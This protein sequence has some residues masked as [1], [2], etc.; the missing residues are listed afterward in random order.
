MRLVGLRVDVSIKASF[1]VR[2]RVR[3]TFKVGGEGESL[4]IVFGLSKVKVLRFSVRVTF[5]AVNIKVYSYGLGSRL[6]LAL[7]RARAVSALGLLMRSMSERVIVIP[8]HVAG[9][10][11]NAVV[12][13]PPLEYS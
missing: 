2:V 5:I 13:V 11:L 1:R 12:C 7:V 4:G 10:L 3:A 6:R 9:V 8:T